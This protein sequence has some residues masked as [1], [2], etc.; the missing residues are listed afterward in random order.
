MEFKI[1]ELRIPFRRLGYLLGIWLWASKLTGWYLET[2]CKAATPKNAQSLSR[3]GEALVCRRN[4]SDGFD[5][6]G[7]FQ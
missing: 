2:C 3:K 6:D 5:G 7:P 4:P 1:A